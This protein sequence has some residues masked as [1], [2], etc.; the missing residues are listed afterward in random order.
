MNPEQGIRNNL[1]RIQ[2]KILSAQETSEFSH[3]I[4]IVGVTKTHPPEIITAAINAGLTN[5][6]ENRVQEALDKFNKLQVVN[7][8]TKHMIGH[9]QTNK[10]KQAIQFFD[11]IQSVD[12]LRLAKAIDRRSTDLGIQQPILIQVNT[13]GEASK[14]GIMPNQVQDFIKQASTYSN[15]Q[16]KGLMTI[17]KPEPD[18]E[19]VR[20]SFSMLRK[21]RDDIATQNLINVDMNCLSMGMTNDFGVAIEEGANCIRIGRS[22]FGERD[23][24][25]PFPLATW[26]QPNSRQLCH[27]HCLILSSAVT[28][29]LSATASEIS[30]GDD[31]IIHNLKNLG[32]NFESSLTCRAAQKPSR[33]VDRC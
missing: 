18:P 17:G 20:P 3:P 19:S 11:L 15:I 25:V 5:I 16:I 22:I 28:V 31:K 13:S 24:S 12:S 23:V 32:S 6:G 33:G 21:L 8:I 9:L 29:S 1:L 30:K 27:N 14:F 4:T 26:N 10:I 7:R 2:E